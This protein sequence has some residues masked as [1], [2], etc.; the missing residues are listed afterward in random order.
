ML[1]KK[2]PAIETVIQYK[3]GAGGGLMWAQMNTLPADGLNV[4]GIN[5][6]HIVLQPMEG[7]SRT[8]PKT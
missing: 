2:C 4:V 5:L 6:P 1:K 7:R 3:P 8:R